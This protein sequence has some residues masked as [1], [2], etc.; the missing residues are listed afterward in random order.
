MTRTEIF[1]SQNWI[2]RVVFPESHTPGVLLLGTAYRVEKRLGDNLE[3]KKFSFEKV[4][5]RLQVQK[6][7]MNG[8]LLSLF[9]DA[10]T[11]TWDSAVNS[12]ISTEL[13][14]VSISFISIP[15]ASKS[16]NVYL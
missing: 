3:K 7:L 8:F 9:T 4:S 14:Y 10:Q 13:T 6:R 15:K 2:I 11:A 16:A 12:K 1:L 5:M